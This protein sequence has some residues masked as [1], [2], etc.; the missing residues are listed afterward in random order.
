MQVG[1]ML[2]RAKTNYINYFNFYRRLLR[3]HTM[4]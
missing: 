1:M 2:L 4:S 3:V